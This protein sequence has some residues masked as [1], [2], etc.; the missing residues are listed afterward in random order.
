MTKLSTMTMTLFKSKED[1]RRAVAAA[2]EEFFDL[3]R[4]VLAHSA[5]TPQADDMEKH[6]TIAIAFQSPDC[7]PAWRRLAT[8]TL[9]ALDPRAD[10]T[11]EQERIRDIAQ[12]IY[13]IEKVV[14]RRL[15]I[16]LYPKDSEDAYQ[17]ALETLAPFTHQGEPQ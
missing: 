9:T 17:R 15:G 6:A 2:Y 10:L 8:Y 11:A 16:H 5:D 3:A 14:S 13:D 12:S 4:F 1:Y 7:D